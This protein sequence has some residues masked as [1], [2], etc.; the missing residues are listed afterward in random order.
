M[1][2]Q[3]LFELFGYI[4]FIALIIILLC[5]IGFCIIFG[6]YELRVAKDFFSYL[7]GKEQF[8]KWR[9]GQCQI[10]NET[11]KQKQCRLLSEKTKIEKELD[12]IKNGKDM[13]VE[14]IKICKE[15]EKVDD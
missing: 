8:L 3:F 15:E 12:S 1:I 13:D 2:K 9:D 4:G 10:A 6:A 11:V 5:I 7:W 14:M